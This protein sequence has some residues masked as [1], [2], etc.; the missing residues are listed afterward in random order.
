MAGSTASS[1]RFIRSLESVVW[2]IV[3]S[4]RQLARCSGDFSGP[5]AKAPAMQQCD[6]VSGLLCELCVSALSFSLLFAP[7]KLKIT[8]RRRER[9][10]AQRTERT[11]LCV[12]ACRRAI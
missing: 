8:Q 7:A 6:D 2:V 4:A 9:R 5:C 10:V 12:G 1:G 3:G 11:D